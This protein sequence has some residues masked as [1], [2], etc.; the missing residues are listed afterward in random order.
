MIDNTNLPE[1]TIGT[2]SSTEV[3]TFFDRYFTQEVSFPSNQIDSVLGFFLKRGFDEQSARSTSIVLLNQA[4]IENVSPFKLIDTLKGLTDVQLSQVVAT[5]LNIY[6]EKTSA[7]GYRL[8]TLISLTPRRLAFQTGNIEDNEHIIVF[9]DPHQFGNKTKVIYEN[10]NNPNITGLKN[11]SIYYVSV[12]NEKKIKLYSDR[13]LTKLVL[14]STYL[15]MH[16]VYNET[17]TYEV[18][19]I[20]AYEKKLYVTIAQ[21]TG[22]LP[23]NNNFF[24]LYTEVH[25]LEEEPATKEIPVIEETF[26]TRNIRQ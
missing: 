23:T 11:Q 16:P 10:N 8:T 7:V 17:D 25:Q 19:D 14:L 6:R 9:D 21:S 2:D 3:R 1:S 12:I 4:R 26:E 15:G 24:T 18:G 20:V 5:V 13:P 22:N